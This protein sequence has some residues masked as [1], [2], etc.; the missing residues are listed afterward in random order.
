MGEYTG[1]FQSDFL[2]RFVI[3]LASLFV[4]LRLI[5]YR[6]V[7]H[8]DSLGGFL[9]FGN[10]VFLVTALLHDAEMSMGFAFGLFAVFSMLRYR[11]ETI[12]IRDMS[13]LFVLIAI[14]LMCAVSSL[15][16]LELIVVVGFMCG[17]AKTCETTLLVNRIVEKKIV[18]EKIDYIKPENLEIL[19]EDLEHRIGYKIER[20]DVGDVDFLRDIAHLKVYYLPDSITVSDEND[21]KENDTK[22]KST[23]KKGSKKSIEHS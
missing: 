21:V 13:Y 12:T 17:L 23:K 8:K 11:T 4:L 6:D 1:I 5:Y 16:H 10:G 19:R 18:Y 3:N 14:A 7:S 9:L 15:S 2:A 22:K 20:I